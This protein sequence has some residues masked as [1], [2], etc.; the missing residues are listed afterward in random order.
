MTSIA[1]RCLSYGLQF[2]TYNMIITG[3]K[4]MIELT[5]DGLYQDMEI[6]VKSQDNTLFNDKIKHIHYKLRKSMKDLAIIDELIKESIKESIE[7]EMMEKF[8]KYYE[9]LY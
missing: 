1:S 6:L 5:I 3:Q 2:T 9:E 4:M 7:R 8:D